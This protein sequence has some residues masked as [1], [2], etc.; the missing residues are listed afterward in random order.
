[1]TDQ[2]LNDYLKADLDQQ[3]FYLNAVNGVST[4]RSKVQALMN[5]RTDLAVLRVQA[6]NLINSWVYQYAEGLK[7]YIDGC[8]E[9]LSQ[10]QLKL[11]SVTTPDDPTQELV[12]QNNFKAKVAALSNAELLQYC[13][14]VTE[15]AK[16]G[17][18]LNDFQYNTLKAAANG[19][20]LEATSALNSYD[21]YKDTQYQQTP[22]YQQASNNLKLASTA[23]AFSNVN[24][25]K[26]TGVLT[27][28]E[29]MNLLTVATQ[30]PQ[31][32]ILQTKDFIVPADLI[33]QDT[34]DYILT[35]ET[36]RTPEN[37]TLIDPSATEA[38][39][40]IQQ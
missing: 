15:E 16:N 17:K 40:S 10:L 27:D 5:K 8:N 21:Y 35:D 11:T 32:L 30:Q 37:M 4:I 23:L 34:K 33:N 9:Y 24:K 26:Q 18:F 22:E 31:L 1:M 38:Q 28:N 36:Q 6:A 2:V 12:D 19:N 3:D 7:H 29:A 20:S 39:K 14:Q 13:K 25:I